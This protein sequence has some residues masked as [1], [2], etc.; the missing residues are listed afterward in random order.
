MSQAGSLSQVMDITA[1]AAATGAT[2]PAASA[3]GNQR[4]VLQYAEEKQQAKWPPPEFFG[5]GHR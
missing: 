3:V 4:N 5:F 2:T 1:D